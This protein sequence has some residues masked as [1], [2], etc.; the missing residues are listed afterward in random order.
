VEEMI[1][2]VP[3]ADLPKGKDVVVV[4]RGIATT[5]AGRYQQGVQASDSLPAGQ[6]LVAVIR[7]EELSSPDQ[8]TVTS[9]EQAG[10]KFKVVLRHLRY[11]GA[12]AANV[13]TVALLEIE[14]GSLSAGTYQVEVTTNV[15]TFGDINRPQDTAPS[16]TKLQTASFTVV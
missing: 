13:V 8:I 6:D 9:H 2:K 4:P 1:V 16:G 11:T 5:T 3:P 14:L 10:E 15:F 12:L 7:S